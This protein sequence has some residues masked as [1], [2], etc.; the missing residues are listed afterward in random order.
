[1]S[2]RSKLATIIA[3]AGGVIISSLLVIL[4]VGR[5]AING[6]AALVRY[7]T[8]IG[9]LQDTLSTLKDAETGQRGYLLTG[10]DKYL[11]PHEQAVA[12]IHQQFETLEIRAREGELSAQDVAALWHLA[13]QK[14]DELQET[15]VLRRTQGLPAA[16]AVVETDFGQNK[17][18][19][20]RAQ[21]AKMTGIEERALTSA[22]RR[23]AELVYYSNA[24]F[25]LSSLLSLGVLFWAY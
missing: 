8:V 12:R 24:I 13:S 23:A 16:L 20:I 6:N 14:L 5:A 19:S 11:V 21:V 2:Q 15:I 22:N 3:T 25:V 9:E 17:M 7:H 18:D 10:K 4:F 1:M